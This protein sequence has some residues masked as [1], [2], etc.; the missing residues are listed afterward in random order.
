[1]ARSQLKLYK[2][3][4][5]EHLRVLIQDKSNLGALSPALLFEVVSADDGQFRLEC[6]GETDLTDRRPGKHQG[7]RKKLA[8]A[9]AFLRQKLADGPKHAKMACR[10]GQGHCSKRTLDEA[11]KNLE[12]DTP[13]KGKGKG[14]VVSWALPTVAKPKQRQAKAATKAKKPATKP[15]QAKIPQAKPASKM[16]LS[17]TPRAKSTKV[18]LPKASEIGF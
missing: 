12:I 7:R 4:E 2:H 15:P 3:P 18:R 5:D 6:R 17:K 11:K 10:A 9:E 16:P 13:R 14:H 8:A 1:M